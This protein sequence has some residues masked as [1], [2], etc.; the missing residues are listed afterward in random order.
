MENNY[1]ESRLFREAKR[2]IPGGVNSPVRSFKAVGG[3]PVFVKEAKGSKV[4]GE[5]AEEFI[6]Y[7]LSWGALILGHTHPKVVKALW[8]AIGKG[9]SF[10]TATKL[11]IELAKLIVEAIPSIEQVRLTNSGTEAVMSAIRLAR[12]FTKKN[13]I[14]KFEGSY[15]GHA[16]Y[17]LVK[18]GSAQAALG[19]PNS[20]GIPKDFTKHTI[21]I[22]YNHI[23]RVKEVA[24][25]YQKDL[26][27]IIVEPVAGN[28]GVIKP[29]PGFLETLRKIADKYNL[30]LI[31]DEV[32]TGFRLIFGGAQEYFSVKPDLTCLGKIIGGGLPVGA[33][34]G[35]REIMQL[36]APQGDVYQAGTLSG[37]PLAVTAGITTL[38]VLKEVNPYRAL[39]KKT[40]DLCEKVKLKAQQYHIK[41]KVNYIGSMFSVF[42]TN[43]EVIDYDSA[44][45]QDLRIFKKFY[46]SFLKE[47][48]YLSPSAFEANFLSIVHTALDLERTLEAIDKVLA[49]LSRK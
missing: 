38:N 26:A 22:P 18:G 15:H 34:G 35:K 42:F 19:I 40:E 25:K 39:E 14:I 6:D 27:G 12:A 36:L 46:H 41:L 17:L 47:G 10:G 13:K 8:G 5:C 24:K 44:C 9:T 30:V 1:L 31:F 28:C 16:D 43:K 45:L 48:I 2:Y 37:N 7:C 20:L 3:Y 4:Y 11:E 21:V 29:L 32:I 49:R 23:K 33:F